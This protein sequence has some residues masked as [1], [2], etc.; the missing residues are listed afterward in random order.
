MS[1]SRDTTA[2]IRSDDGLTIALDAG[3]KMICKIRYGVLNSVVDGIHQICIMKS[4]YLLKK[5]CNF[6]YMINVEFADGTTESINLWPVAVPSLVNFNYYPSCILKIDD[7]L[8]IRQGSFTSKPF[9]GNRP[10]DDPSVA[11]MEVTSYEVLLTDGAFFI[12]KNVPA[13]DLEAGDVYLEDPMFQNYDTFKGSVFVNSAVGQSSG[14]Y[15][16]CLVKKS[17]EEV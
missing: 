13:A 4:K 12:I 1:L 17:E 8:K 10:L 15:E 7:K 11:L 6:E 5:L 9:L 2:T 14:A 3:D 16:P